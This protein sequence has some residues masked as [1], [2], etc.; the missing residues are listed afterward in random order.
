MTRRDF[1]C[2]GT[3]PLAEKLL[4]VVVMGRPFVVP[5]KTKSVLASRAAVILVP[6]GSELSP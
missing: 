6:G 3:V 5:L 4:Q 2:C 1:G